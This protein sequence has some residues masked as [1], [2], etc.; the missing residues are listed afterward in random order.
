M[1]GVEFIALIGILAS[2]EQLVE[3]SGRLV[4]RAV[5]FYR[6]SKELPKTLEEL[7]TVG[8]FLSYSSKR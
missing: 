4:K 8:I 6:E 1:S 3:N 5:G 7:Q 2:I